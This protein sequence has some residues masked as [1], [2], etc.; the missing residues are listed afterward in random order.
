VAGRG[1]PGRP[2]GQHR[3]LAGLAGQARRNLAA[4]G[5]GNVV[6]LAGDRT[7]GA[8]AVRPVRRDRGLRLP[9]RAV[10]AGAWLTVRAVWSSRGR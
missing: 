3:H 2:R 7:G 5:V 9:W 8:P 1:S 10:A 6:V 4:H